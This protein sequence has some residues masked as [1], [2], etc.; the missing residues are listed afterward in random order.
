[1]LELADARQLPAD[2][3]MKPDS[4]APSFGF[5]LDHLWVKLELR[6]QAPSAQHLL[7]EIAY[8]PLD[9]LEIQLVRDG[10]LAERFQLGDTLPFSQRPIN[11]RN[12]VVPVPMDR[13]ESVTLYLKV[14][15]E[16]TLQAP[17]KLWEHQTF[18][19]EQ[20]YALITQGLYF[21]IMLVMILY[22]LFLY[23]TVR[24]P[25]YLYY[26]GSVLGMSCITAA[27]PGI[28]V[29]FIWPDLPAFNAVAI[30]V[31]ISAFDAMGGVFA[32]SLLDV[33][34]RAPRVH[35]FLAVSAWFYGLMLVPAFLLP[36]HISV[37]VIGLIGAVCS[38]FVFFMGFYLWSIGVRV[39]RFY[40][41]AWSM[42]LGAFFL[43]A[44]SKLGVIGSSFWLEHSVQI[45]SAAE[46]VLLSFALAD[47]INTERQEK[48]VAQQAAL[49]AQ[50]SLANELD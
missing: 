21:G 39:A 8:P 28:G 34:D 31:S 11:H 38:F 1:T 46:V 37:L 2:A 44:I 41:L 22:N 40:A 4:E 33:N 26:T 30:P 19:S 3:W 7:L 50:T 6:N 45:G 29:Q 47:R 18:H 24:H 15:T 25:S 13:G 9:H 10:E 42:L 16:G 14:K 32:I 48:L 35:A 49:T 5:S 23:F 43:T 12:F 17:I 20:Q 27:L 36:Y